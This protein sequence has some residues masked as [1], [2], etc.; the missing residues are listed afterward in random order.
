MNQPYQPFIG[1]VGEVLPQEIR[2]LDP[3]GQQWVVPVS[4]FESLP[5]PGDSIALLAI[6]QGG[7]AA[8]KSAFAKSILNELL[9]SE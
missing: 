7:E 9:A 3:T 4:A 1:K 6:P 5:K 8:G 2:L